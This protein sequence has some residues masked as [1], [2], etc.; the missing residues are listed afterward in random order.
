MIN[1]PYLVHNTALH[2]IT[3]TEEEDRIEKVSI[4]LLPWLTF[5]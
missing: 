4:S 1:K 3:L 2:I 5:K